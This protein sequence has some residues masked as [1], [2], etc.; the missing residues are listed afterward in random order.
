VPL[1]KGIYRAA[2]E[3][4]RQFLY[5]AE[6]DRGLDY[7]EDLASPGRLEF[8]IA[9]DEAV[10][11]LRVGDG[12][13]VSAAPLAAKLVDEERQRRGVVPDELVAAANVFLADG[14][15][16]RRLLAGLPWFTDWG[17]DTFIA[18]RGLL[19]QPDGSPK[20]RQSSRHG[21]GWSVPACCPTGVTIRV[22][23]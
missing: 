16:G 4:Y 9:R 17:R 20:P 19:L 23:R 8:D 5:I 7:V 13:A 21:P 6:R 3:W 11:I 15:H 10:L 1:S 22:A 12:P 18:L 14:T 2:P